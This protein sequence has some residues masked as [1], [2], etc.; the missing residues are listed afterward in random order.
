MLT[1]TDHQSRET[2]P[3]PS[4]FYR[5]TWGRMHNNVVTLLPN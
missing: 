3:K 2:G 4:G 5:Y 1:A